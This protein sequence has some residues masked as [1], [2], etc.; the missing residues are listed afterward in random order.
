M[1]LLLSGRLPINPSIVLLRQL[2][3]QFLK[4]L[5]KTPIEKRLWI[6]EMERIRIYKSDLD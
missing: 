3:N 1:G 5:E 6:V 2:I 4:A